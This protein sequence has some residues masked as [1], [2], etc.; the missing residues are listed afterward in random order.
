M[1]Q[2]PD[3]WFYYAVTLAFG[4]ALIWVIIR[5]TGKIDTTLTEIQKTNHEMKTMLMLHEQKLETH[6][7]EIDDLKQKSFT[8]NYRK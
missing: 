4:G 3:G 2:A 7:G 5:Y 6:D 8:V 1:Q